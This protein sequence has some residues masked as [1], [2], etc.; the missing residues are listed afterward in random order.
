MT[1][2]ATTTSAVTAP[3]PNYSRRGLRPGGHGL[4]G[5]HFPGFR[6]PS[7]T[8]ENE[9]DPRGSFA[10]LA[11]PIQSNIAESF[12]K[13]AI[14]Y[15]G[16]L[17]LLLVLGLPMALVALLIRVSSP[18]PAIYRQERVGLGGRRF[19]MLKFRT[20]R[21]DAEDG[22]GPVWAEENDPRRTFF[23]AWLRRLSIDE[24][25]QLINVVKGEMSLVG[26]RP[27]RPYFVE[28]FSAEMPEYMR[29]HAAPPGMTGWAQLNGLRG[30]T[31]ISRRLDFDLHYIRNWSAP[32]DLFILILTPFRLLNEKHAY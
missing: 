18:G 32:F 12:C 5:P 10:D 3:S 13:R 8:L 2:I 15:F 1:R 23:G 31:S 27:E 25:P 26:P 4:A 17:A 21:V 24:L 14:D 20:M 16:S 28:R 11:C 6:D 30:N 29:R 22:T 7:S 9:P 19:M